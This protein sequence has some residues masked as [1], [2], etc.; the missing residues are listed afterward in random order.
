MKALCSRFTNTKK[1]F[2]RNVQ[3]VGMMLPKTTETSYRCKD[4]SVQSRDII[5]IYASTFY[6][7]HFS[8]EYAMGLMGTTMCMER[9]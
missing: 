8:A 3:D 4:G 9:V 5:G 6:S 2:S 1:H 7:W